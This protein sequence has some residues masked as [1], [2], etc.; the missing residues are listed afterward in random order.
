MI[1]SDKDIV[2]GIVRKTISIEPFN[3][4]NLTP[5]G[6]DLTIDEILIPSM[7]KKIKY[8]DVEISPKTWF[9]ISTKE[10]V[11]ISG[12]IVGQLWIRTSYARK[13][14]LSSFG[15]IDAG[16]EGNLTLSA[17]NSSEK[18]VKISIGETFAQVILIKI[19]S[20]PK[21]LYEQHSGNYMRQK[22]IKLK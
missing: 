9:L 7:E 20:L 17:F 11:K 10:Y 22:G 4:K 15:M 13:G 6:Y 18:S 16:F 19:L 14:I 3:S 21:S 12:E 2:E 5:N 1:L 8:G